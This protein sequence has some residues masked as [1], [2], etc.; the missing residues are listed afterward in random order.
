MVMSLT[1]ATYSNLTFTRDNEENIQVQLRL[2]ST[3]KNIYYK[4]KLTS[5][6]T[7]EFSGGVM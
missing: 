4:S 3:R 2:K 5:L 7:T 6:L 1:L